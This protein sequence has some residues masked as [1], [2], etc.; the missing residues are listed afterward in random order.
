MFYCYF[1]AFPQFLTQPGSITSL[2]ESYSCVATGNPQP[3]SIIW[4]S[5]KGDI[6]QISTTN[7][8]VLNTSLIMSAPVGRYSCVARNGVGD[9]VVEFYIDLTG[10]H[11]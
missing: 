5:P 6:L 11:N 2:T 3:S 4:R 9:S 8:L 1:A 10:I 7:T